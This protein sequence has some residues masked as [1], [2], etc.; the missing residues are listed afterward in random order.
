[1]KIRRNL[2]II[3]F[4]LIFLVVGLCL[5]KINLINS[6]ILSPLNEEYVA[7]ND[8]ERELYESYSDFIKD[9]SLVKLYIDDNGDV[10]IK[11]ADKGYR[12]KKD[13]KIDDIAKNIFN[14]IEVIFKSL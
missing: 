13:L 7:S 10:L 6:K 11:I 1:M 8:E 14:K 5:I 2:M 4:I 12:I 3:S 9:E